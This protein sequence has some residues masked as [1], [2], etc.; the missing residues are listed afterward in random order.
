MWRRNDQRFF[1]CG[2]RIMKKTITILAATLLTAIAGCATYEPV[3]SMRGI[4]VA[5]PDKAPAVLNFVGKR[6]GTAGQDKIA[7]TFAEQPPMV[8]HAMENFDD[9]NLQ[10]NQCL[11][12]HGP[13]KYVEKKAPKLGDSHFLDRN[14]LKLANV[15]AARHNCTQC[16]VA[17]VDAPPLVENR[18]IGNLK[19]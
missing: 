10:E 12:C 7:R 8:P 9:I 19:Q 13:A 15:S 6:P 3:A 4:D 2:E 5:A 16:H 14:G 11:D 1:L 18:F 17:Q